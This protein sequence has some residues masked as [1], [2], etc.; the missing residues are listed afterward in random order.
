MLGRPLC[1]RWRRGGKLRR[2]IGERP[3][4]SFGQV[5]TVVARHLLD[6]LIQHRAVDLAAL[7]DRA[8][9]QQAGGD[10]V[11]PARNTAARLV[12]LRE[13][14]GVEGRVTRPVHQ[15]QAMLDIGRDLMHLHRRQVMRRDHAL[16][17][18]FQ[19]VVLGE[20]LL[21][22][23]LA[24]QQLLQQRVRAKLEVGHHPQLFERFETEV[25]RL[26]HD[27]QAAAAIARFL[28]QERLDRTERAGLVLPCDVE[29][30]AL[31]HQMDQFG[32]IEVAGNDLA[33]GHLVGIDLLHQVGDHRRLARP[34]L[35][36]DDDEALAL[37]HPVTEIAQRLSMRDALEIERRV[38]RELE[39]SAGETVILVE[40]DE[41]RVP[42]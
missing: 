10:L 40:H 27:Q 1:R 18:L 17:Q 24:E 34:D 41:V 12:D 6:H 7:L 42:G 20:R 33:N 30:K 2:G 22:F 31:R 38:G 19:P 23:G 5:R 37:R 25:L 14:L 3:L 39:W 29:A 9:Q 26:V 21:E 11:D 28:V 32:A 16:A 36:G 4:A 13:D 8:H 35:A 15:R